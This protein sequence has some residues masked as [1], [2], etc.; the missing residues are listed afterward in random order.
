MIEGEAIGCR[1]HPV[2]ALEQIALCSSHGPRLVRFAMVM[3]DEVQQSVNHQQRQLIID[4]PGMTGRLVA[5]HLRTDDDVAE[6]NRFIRRV[7]WVDVVAQPIGGVERKREHIGWSHHLHELSIQRRHLIDIDEA[8]RQL[9]AQAEMF[10]SL[11]RKQPPTI[12]ID[13]NR[14]LFIGHHHDALRHRITSA[15]AFIRSD[16]VGDDPVADH[17]TSGQVHE[18][19]LIDTAEHIFE[20]GQTT[21]A[22]GDID[23]GPVAGHDDL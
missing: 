11:R 3:A 23:L 6:Q 7:W 22:V 10:R 15:A 16:D 1:P 12:T 18:C 20:S 9:P 5:C 21:A 13:H 14:R 17:I 2:K 8:Q 4:G 19:Q